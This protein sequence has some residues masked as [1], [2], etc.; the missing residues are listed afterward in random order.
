MAWAIGATSAWPNAQTPFITH[1]NSEPRHT[2]P[3]KL[4][5][6]SG[7]VLVGNLHHGLY[8]I[9]RAGEVTPALAERCQWK[10]P[11]ELECHLKKDLKYSDGSPIHAQDFVK[12]IAH[13][14]AQKSPHLVKLTHLKKKN[15][16]VAP[17][18]RLLKW[19]FAKED[20]EFIE[21][22]ASP[23]LSPRPKDPSKIFSGPYQLAQWERG[24]SLLLKPNP[25]YPGAR[26]RPHVRILFV[27]EDSTA[28]RLFDLNKIHLLRNVSTSEIPKRKNQPGFVFQP[29]MR[30]D[31]IGFGKPL[32]DLF[33][34]RKALSLSLRF[35]EL[36]QLYL[37]PGQVGC[38][39]LP[40]DLL[41]SPNR[42][43]KFDPVQAKK[44]LG[45]IVDPSP[46]LSLFYSSGGG[47]N[48]ALGMEWVQEQWRKHLG[49]KIEL[50]PMEFG[51]FISQLHHGTPSIF[52]RAVYLDRPTCTAALEGFTTDHQENLM[53]WS[54]LKF[55]QLIQR[56]LQGKGQEKV[57]LCG[58]ALELL[59]KDFVLIPLGEIHIGLQGKP[60]YEGWFLNRMGHLDLSELRASPSAR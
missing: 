40:D 26:D 3:T 46:K 25:K 20:P 38:P 6:A 16:V 57:Q 36:T 50:K 5:D 52:R 56:A 60:T 8:R 53:G 49:L 24:T 2:D 29:I 12:T 19:N 54:S 32:K 35:T 41:P 28:A 37:S 51:S 9:N 48:V 23:V 30:F 33:Q 27:D 45:Q 18:D 10:S 7:G 47:D 39:G 15:G 55:D 22:L 13:L 59:L 17:S 4:V 11:L 14:K 31:H 34:L 1:M 21:K 44:A 58:E 42:C 43:L